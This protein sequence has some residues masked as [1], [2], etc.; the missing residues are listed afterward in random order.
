M[1]KY[2]YVYMMTAKDAF[3]IG[4]RS[5]KCLPEDDIHYQSSSELVKHLMLNGV[6]F[7]KIILGAYDTKAEAFKIENETIR[8]VIHQKECINLACQH[9]SLQLC[10]RIRKIDYLA[11]IFDISLKGWII[12]HKAIAHNKIQKA[13]K[14][15]RKKALKLLKQRESLR[16]QTEVLETHVLGPQLES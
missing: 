1:S 16:M 3:Y 15:Q 6:K 14:H 4:S 8:K 7:N 10:D 2:Y 12:N 11:F 13:Q 9:F 5:C